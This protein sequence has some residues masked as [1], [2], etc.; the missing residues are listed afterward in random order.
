MITSHVTAGLSKQVPTDFLSSDFLNWEN[1]NIQANIT[2]HMKWA[3]NS[4]EHLSFPG[5][6]HLFPSHEEISFPSH[7]EISEANQTL[8]AP[9]LLMI[10]LPLSIL[11]SLFFLLFLCVCFSFCID[12]RLLERTYILQKARYSILTTCRQC[13][14]LLLLFLRVLFQWGTSRNWFFSP[15]TQFSQSH[16]VIYL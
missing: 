7:G 11:H 12:F 8:S 3:L 2:S 10:M 15:K 6:I 13:D 9:G 14:I 4:R 5:T 1:W 16:L